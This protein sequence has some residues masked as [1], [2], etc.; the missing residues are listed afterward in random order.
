[1]NIIWVPS[2]LWGNGTT[3]S[4]SSDDW[5][6]ISFNNNVTLDSKDSGTT[7]F[8]EIVAYWYQYYSHNFLFFFFQGVT[9]MLQTKIVWARLVR[10]SVGTGISSRIVTLIIHWFVF[11]SY[12][13]WYRDSIVFDQARTTRRIAAPSFKRFGSRFLKA[14]ESNKSTVKKRIHESWVTSLKYRK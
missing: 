12:R 5:K 8:L 9:R 2:V 7:I 14:N 6:F 4:H 10:C 11:W 13:Q 1:M 3:N